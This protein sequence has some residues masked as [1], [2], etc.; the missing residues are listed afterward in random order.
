MSGEIQVMDKPVVSVQNLTKEFRLYTSNRQRIHHELLGMDSGERIEVFKGVSFDIYPGERVALIG[1]IGSGRSTMINII[2][3]VYPD[4][5]GKVKLDEAPL[6]M[7]DHK[8]GFDMGL[9]GRNNLRM[10]ASILGMTKQQ[11]A[12]HEQEIIDFVELN[13]VIDNPIKTY[14]SGASNRLGFA[15]ALAMN[16]KLILYDDNYAFGGE[17]FVNKCLDRL[18]DILEQNSGTLIMASTNIGI[19]KRLCTRGIVLNEGKAVYDGEL[20]A[21]LRYFR[22]HCKADPETEKEARKRERAVAAAE[23]DDDSYDDF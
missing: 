23:D 19:T 6:L 12:E 1:N 10:Q 7:V 21:A 20:D 3:E 11:I 13:D 15:T 22:R 16:P 4:H 18:L 5:G 17:K 8:L 9:S 14:K 2:G